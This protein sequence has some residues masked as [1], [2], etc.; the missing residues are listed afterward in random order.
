VIGAQF[1]Y[2][3]DSPSLNMAVHKV[4]AEVDTFKDFVKNMDE[5][6]KKIN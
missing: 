2:T 5:S 4:E 1:F 6:S 3:I